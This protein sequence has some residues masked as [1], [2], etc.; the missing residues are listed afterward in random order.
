[1]GV[2][3]C[4]LGSWGSSLGSIPPPSPTPGCMT[5]GESLGLVLSIW[6]MGLCPALSQPQVGVEISRK[7][8]VGLWDKM[9]LRHLPT[10]HPKA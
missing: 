3:G 7:E 2:L 4:A 6:T 9:V 10:P 1:M 8:R 5:L